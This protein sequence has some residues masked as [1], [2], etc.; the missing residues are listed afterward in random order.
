MNNI[1]V[2]V[3]I[4]IYNSKDYIAKCLDSLLEQTLKEIEII[5]VN[6]GSTDNSQEILEKYASKHDN[7]IIL[8]KENGGCGSARNLGIDNARGEYIEF[9]DSDDQI[10]PDTI[11]KLYL[12]AKKYNSDLVVCGMNRIDDVTGKLITSD[13]VNVKKEFIN[14]EESD[15]N[16]LLFINPGPCNKLHKKEI[17]QNARFPKI[18][19]VDDLMLTLQYIPYIKK[20]SFVKEPLYIYKVRR[21]S[22]VN[23]VEYSTYE[24]M[25]KLF[26]EIKN[27]YIDS[28]LDK[29]YL[30]YIDKMAFIHV[31]VSM[32]YRMAYIKDLNI[33]SEINKT[34]D[35]LKSEFPNWKMISKIKKVT[36]V[37]K[38]KLFSV[39]L[40]CRLYKMHL[41]KLFIN[42]YIFF[43]CKLHIDIKW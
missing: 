41:A 39:K 20:I 16:D 6:D 43:I 7:I 30:D 31:G 2:S 8:N 27:S 29:K 15:L 17:F 32:L 26:V 35:Y 19:V 23:T 36:L 3:I 12:S 14:V 33:N 5:C 11:E 34:L 21:E 9:I 25:K 40:V 38:A 37:S 42:T 4:P 13:M 10:R 24:H 18:P 22:G 28:K 1:K